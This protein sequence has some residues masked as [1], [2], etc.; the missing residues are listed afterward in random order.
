M[1]D[2]YCGFA[3]ASARRD[4]LIIELNLRA[5]SMG[6]LHKQLKCF[7]FAQLQKVGVSAGRSRKSARLAA[8]A[9]A[10]SAAPVCSAFASVSL[11]VP[12]GNNDE[13]SAITRSNS[14]CA[15]GEASSTLSS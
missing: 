7:G 4:A 14:P 8:P 13:L 9:E 3:K 1:L 6:A 12:A 11:D 15:S 2:V 5:C 10:A